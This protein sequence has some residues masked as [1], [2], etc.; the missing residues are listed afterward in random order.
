MA[1]WRA[2]VGASDLVQQTMLEAGRD[3]ESFRGQTPAELKTWLIRILRHNL[4]D[5][6]REYKTA[7]S[8]DI[9]QEVRVVENGVQLTDKQR[10]ASSIYRRVESNQRLDEALALL[11]E[12]YE[13]AIR[14]RHADGLSWSE[15][16]ERL[17]VSPEAARKLWARALA[18][19]REK[20]AG[21][22]ES[23]IEPPQRTTDRRHR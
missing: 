5:V 23:R 19:L 14:L 17:N 20:L 2:K 11:P 4:T 8:R 16:G 6:A 9:H 18:I 22:Y 10:T 7:Q 15:V 21:D 12:Q 3:I 13:V 1:L